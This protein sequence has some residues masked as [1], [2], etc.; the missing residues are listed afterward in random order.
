MA[1]PDSEALYVVR[2]SKIHQEGVF[3]RVKIPKGEKVIEYIGEKITKKE[4]QRRGS[5]LHEEAMESGGGAVYIFEI[6]KK[7]DIDGN[8]SWNTARL[9]NHS[10]D[11]NC[12]AIQEGNRIWIHAKRK[13]KEGEE[14]S[15]DYGFD[16]DTWEEHPCLCASKNCV[17]FIVAERHWPKLKKLIKEK[18]KKSAK[19][20][21]K[22]SEKKGTKKSKG[23]KKKKG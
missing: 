9:I 4:S 22:K 2:R 20:D 18:E 15:Y 3:A 10:C 17:G 14:L 7:W 12:E 6:N 8:V 11:P 19:K 13:I 1:E 23:K 21:G 5:A 16:L